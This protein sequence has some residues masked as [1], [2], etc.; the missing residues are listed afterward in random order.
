MNNHPL[1][2]ATANAAMMMEMLGQT[3]GAQDDAALF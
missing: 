2:H 3:F 1:G